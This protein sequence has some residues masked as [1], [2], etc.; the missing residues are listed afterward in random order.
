[1]DKNHGCH[2]SLLKRVYWP[3]FEECNVAIT[4]NFKV[5]ISMLEALCTTTVGQE[6]KGF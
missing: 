6:E 4:N 2:F 5:R 1:M 3:T